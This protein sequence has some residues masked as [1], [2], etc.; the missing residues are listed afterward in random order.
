MAGRQKP[1]IK[2]SHKRIPTHAKRQLSEETIPFRFQI[3]DTEIKLGSHPI[4]PRT[5]A[6]RREPLF[7][8]KNRPVT[9][10]THKKSSLGG[11]K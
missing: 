6:A 10:D 5:P 7:S 2:T 9:Q 1:N 3:Q 8:D 4:Q 11:G